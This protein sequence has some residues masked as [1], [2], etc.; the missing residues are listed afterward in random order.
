MVKYRKFKQ[1][2]YIYIYTLNFNHRNI[3]SPNPK[4]C[5]MG[6]GWRKTPTAFGRG[7]ISPIEREYLIAL[8]A[9]PY[10]LSTGSDWLSSLRPGSQSDQVNCSTTLRHL[11]GLTGGRRSPIRQI[12]QIWSS[13]LYSSHRPC[14]KLVTRFLKFYFRRNRRGWLWVICAEK[15]KDFQCSEYDTKLHLIVRLLSWS[16]R[17]MEYFFIIITLRSTL[18]W[19]V[20]ICLIFS[21]LI[22]T[23]HSQQ[24]ICI[25]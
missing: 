20:R 24:I 6:W 5:Q 7:R 23:Y 15:K 14:D 10:I 1:Y 9:D 19:I 4:L 18:T 16:L 17:N 21:S 8:S 3:T 25:W 12:A 2:I 22:E 11:P 13:R